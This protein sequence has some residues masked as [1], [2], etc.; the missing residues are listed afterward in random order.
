MSESRSQQ[1]PYL[2]SYNW[3]LNLP[4]FSER[5]EMFPVFFFKL[6]SHTPARLYLLL[7]S[8]TPLC[9]AGTELNIIARFLPWSPQARVTYPLGAHLSALFLVH[10]YVYLFYSL[11]VLFLIFYFYLLSVEPT[12]WESTFSRLH[13]AL[14]LEPPGGAC[15]L[16]CPTL[17]SEDHW[18]WELKPSM[19]NSVPPSLSLSFIYLLQIHLL[20]M[21]SSFLLSIR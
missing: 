3:V 9:P 21:D 12:G 7:S 17:H 18:L 2:G 11:A 4:S 6:S 20:Q 10:S 1:F 13:A 14:C 16:S 15:L 19:V 5:L 8:F